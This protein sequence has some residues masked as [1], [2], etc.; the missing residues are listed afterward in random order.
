[1]Y[2][3]IHYKKKKI[4]KKKKKCQVSPLDSGDTAEMS[5]S[6]GLVTVILLMLDK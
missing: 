3:K 4:K 1:M 5:S 2:D 6:P